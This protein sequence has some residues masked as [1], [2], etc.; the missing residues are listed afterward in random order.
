M[1]NNSKTKQIFFKIK[2]II[3]H[4]FHK[5]IKYNK[6]KI[7]LKTITLMILIKTRIKLKI[8]PKVSKLTQ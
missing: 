7:M 2:Q 3:H 4:R 8:K 6:I 5:M 1:I